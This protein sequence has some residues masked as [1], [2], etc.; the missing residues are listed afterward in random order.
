MVMMIAPSVT[1]SGAVTG[2][3][4]IIEGAEAHNFIRGYFTD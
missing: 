4:V 2:R 1:Y 3:L